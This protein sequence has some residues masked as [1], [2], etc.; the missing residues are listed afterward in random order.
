[1]AGKRSGL[2]FRLS[3]SWWAYR[4]FI[5]PLLAAAK[6][7]TAR[8]ALRLRPREVLEVGSGTGRQAVL[9]A[10]L[11]LEVTATDLSAR[12]FPAAAR[13]P[14]APAG[15][16][17][18]EA[19]AR[20]LPF[21][22]GAFALVLVSLLLHGLDEAD[23]GAVLREARR[24]LRPGGTLLVLEFDFDPRR[25]RGWT[26]LLIRFF[27]RLAG[28][29]HFGNSMRFLERGGVPAL[30]GREGWRVRRREP[31]LNGR[32]ALFECEPAAPS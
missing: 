2:P 15:P 29:E 19:D 14:R 26:P 17:F 10:R 3:P 22:D 1:M 12:L 7:Q 13:G 6:A 25:E 23:R 5:E 8:A 30:A 21:P 27:E 18:L 20:D 28:A 16:R 32:G 11:G 4:A 31:L 24:V 9:L